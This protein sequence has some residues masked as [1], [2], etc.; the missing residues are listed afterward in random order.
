[1]SHRYGNLC[2]C[3]QPIRSCVHECVIR[4]RRTEI[5]HNHS[6]SVSTLPLLLVQYQPSDIL[7][8][9][10]EKSQEISCV[11]GQTVHDDIRLGMIKKSS[12]SGFTERLANFRDHRSLMHFFFFYFASLNYFTNI[13]CVFS[14]V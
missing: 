10:W 13:T 3:S 9:R 14:F 5:P 6:C 2:A 12:Q 11:L 1:M 8:T 7:N 4:H